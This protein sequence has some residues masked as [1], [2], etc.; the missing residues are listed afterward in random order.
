MNRVF[1][2][3]ILSILSFILFIAGI[4][5][6]ADFELFIAVGFGILLLIHELGHVFALKKLNMT[7]GGIYFIPFLGAITTNKDK[8]LTENNYAYFKYLGPLMGT[9]GAFFVFLLFLIFKD[10]RFLFLSCLGAIFNLINLIPLVILDGY[11]I[12]RG[13]VKHLRW[14][15]LLIIIVFGIFIFKEYV[16]TLFFLLIFTLFAE[17][18][19]EYGY[20]LY[21][22]ILA[23]LYIFIMIYLTISEKEFL[24]SDISIIIF[25]IYAFGMYIK[26]TRYDVKKKIVHQEEILLKLTKKQKI[27]WILKWTLLTTFLVCMSLYTFNSI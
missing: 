23:I 13:S 19:K 21:E 16:I 22:V 25:S 24:V 3:Y 1:I 27:G 11:G 18:E 5:F 10:Q 15:G 12:L 20:K 2:K 7:T 26:A 6:L 4:Y 17:G 8:M 14:I 9:L